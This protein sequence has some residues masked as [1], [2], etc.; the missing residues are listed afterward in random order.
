MDAKPQNQM[1]Q[2]LREAFGCRDCPVCRYADEREESHVKEFRDLLSEE[3]FRKEYEATDGLCR[4]H[5]KLLKVQLET[6]FS[7]MRSTR[8]LREEK[9][10]WLVAIE[11][12]VGKRGLKN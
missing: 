11:K 1:K 4:M 5:L 12:M 7:K 8:D 9:D 3:S 6:F 10:S 2:S